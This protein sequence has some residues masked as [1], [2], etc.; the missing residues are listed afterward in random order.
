MNQLFR[1]RKKKRGRKW[2]RSVHFHTVK[3]EILPALDFQLLM[4]CRTLTLPHKGSQW[5]SKIQLQH[6]SPA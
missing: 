1:D 3:V 2:L 5:I 6:T 4:I